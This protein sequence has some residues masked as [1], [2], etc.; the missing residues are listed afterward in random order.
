[1][2]LEQRQKYSRT[3]ILKNGLPHGPNFMFLE[4]AEILE[5]GKR[6]IGRLV[7]REQ[8]PY[9]KDHFPGYEIFPGA[10][11]LEAL[12]E[13]TGIAVIQNTPTD[14]NKI[15][16]L[17]K[18]IEMDFKQPIEPDDVIDLEAEIIFFRLNTGR[19]RVKAIKNGTAAIEGEIVF[20]IGD[21]PTQ[22]KASPSLNFVKGS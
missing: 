8:F 1:M 11:G 20:M 16:V 22:L 7:D 15:G 9:L 13:L 19:A 5:P 3:D 6:I 10:L 17:R 12:A 18:I 14:G 21:K 4:W 2:G